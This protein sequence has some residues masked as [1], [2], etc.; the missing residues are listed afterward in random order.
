[1][2]TE[3]WRQVEQLCH[4]ALARPA[5]ERAAFVASAAAGDV[6]LQREVESLLAQEPRAEG[7]MSSPAVAFVASSALAQGNGTLVGRRF[8]SYVLGSRIG[9]GG[10]GEVY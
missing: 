3:R 9:A 8:G 2:A 4:E 6:G 10:M 1:M 7:F 5:E